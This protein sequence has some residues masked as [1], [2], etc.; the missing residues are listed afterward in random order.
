[1][2]RTRTT[3]YVTLLSFILALALTAALA[4]CGSDEP[5]G[6]TGPDRTASI[7]TE[8]PAS[9]APT[10]TTPG[11]EEAPTATV[12]PVPA[13]APPAASPPPTPSTTGSEAAPTATVT[14]GPA[15]MTAPP[16]A[17]GSVETDR[18]ALV[19]LYNANGEYWKRSNNWLSDAPLG[20]WEGVVTNDDGRI[21]ELQLPTNDLSGE[22]PPEL[23]SLSNLSLLNFNGNDLSGEIPA[24][25]GSLSNLT[26]LILT[27]NDLSGEIPP[28]LGSLSNLS[29]LYLAGNDLNGE[30]PPEL[31][32]LSN[33]TGLW[34]SGNELSGCAP[35]S[36]ED[37]LDF[38]VSDL[39]DLPYCPTGTPSTPGAEAAASGSVETDREALVALYNAT[40]GENWNQSDNW[41][42]DAPLGEWEGVVTNDDG[43]IT[44][45]QLHTNALSGEIPAWLGS[46]SNLTWL[47]LT[48]NELSGEI[49][50]ELGSLSNLRTLGLTHNELSG[51][52]PPELGS[53]SNLTSLGLGGNVLSGE[54][55]AELGSLSNLQGLGLGGNVLSGEIPVELGSLSNLTHLAPQRQRV[56]RGDTAVSWAASPG[57][58]PRQRLERVRAKQPGRPGPWTD[59]LTLT[60]RPSAEATRPQPETDGISSW[61]R[62]SACWLWRMA[63]P[64][65]G[66]QP[67]PSSASRSTAV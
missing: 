21:T 35:R 24:W 19:A 48:H 34:L 33:L 30:I 17:S 2:T 14:P 66:D 55:P 62:S 51:E 43:R 10:P 37:Q 49:P 12:A 56:D 39:G 6:V 1:M 25:L 67:L 13:A 16:A 27:D 65:N 20:E 60:A 36:L 29:F 8:T 38:S 54:I 28:E 9:P 50:V 52:I 31:G 44:E 11:S 53:L 4:A 63:L 26:H 5:S 61:R 46:L 57:C 47:D 42:S 32:N 22:I 58:H 45:M 23:G 41:L 15:A 40:D 3:R 18:E 59:T 64:R 7:P